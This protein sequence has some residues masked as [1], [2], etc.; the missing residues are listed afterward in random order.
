MNKLKKAFDPVIWDQDARVFVFLFTFLRVA[1]SQHPLLFVSDFD[2][3]SKDSGLR[4]DVRVFLYG[5]LTAC[6]NGAICALKTPVTTLAFTELNYDP[7]RRGYTRVPAAVTLGARHP[8]I[9]DN[10]SLWSQSV[11]RN[12]LFDRAVD[13]GEPGGARS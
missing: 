6:F 8:T 2:E 10:K 12:R 4:M 9:A 5:E 7:S 3:E 11:T 1:G 13:E